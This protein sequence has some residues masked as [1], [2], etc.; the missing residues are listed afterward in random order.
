MINYFNKFIRGLD[1]NEGIDRKG[2]R[3]FCAKFDQNPTWKHRHNTVT[4][5]DSDE[6]NWDDELYETMKQPMKQ[7]IFD[8][9]SAKDRK[10]FSNE[11]DFVYKNYGAIRDN[12]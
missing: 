5:P 12:D 1:I 7:S 2:R 10:Y 8:P 9:Y 4:L 3:V 11:D 6:N